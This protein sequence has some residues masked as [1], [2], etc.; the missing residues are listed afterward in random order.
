MKRYDLRSDTITLPT[1]GM[2]KAMAAATVGDDVYG[3]DPT[4]NELQKRAAEISG[5]EKSLFVTS[6][7]QANLISLYL[8]GGRGNE[9]I[10]SSNAHIVQHEIASLT[11]LAG[12]LP[13]TV[14]TQDGILQAN[15]IKKIIKPRGFYDM[16]YT[17]LIEVEN[18]IG[19]NIYTKERLSDILSLAKENDL[20]VHMD[21]ARIFNASVATGIPVKTYASYADTVSFCLSKGLGAPVGS[22]LCGDAAFIEKAKRLRKMLG[23]GMRQTGILAA[24]GLYALDNHIERLE[25]DHIGATNLARALEQSSW[26]KVKGPVQTNLVLF[27]VDGLASP[28]VVE[29]LKTKGILCNTEGSYVRLVTHLNLTA[30]DIDELCNLLFSFDPYQEK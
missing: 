10:C 5:K 11:A 28:L 23:S 26:A 19:G 7:S 24:A 9:I 30:N 15:E 2:R 1:D 16:A 14:P 25:E 22:M 17:S 13:Q 21:G 6:G 18:T 27:S 8:N 3:E 12:V 29:K 4:T 20:K